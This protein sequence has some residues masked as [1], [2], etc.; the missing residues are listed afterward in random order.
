[1]FDTAIAPV[2]LAPVASGTLALASTIESAKGYAAASKAT[3]TRR[4]YRGAW[5][6][7]AAWCEAHGLTSLPAAPETVALYLAERADQ[8][9]KPASLDLYLAAVS[10]AHRA[11]GHPSPREAAAVRAVRAGIRRTHGTAQRQVAPATA[12]TLR[13]M[14]AELPDG[15]I[16][17]RDAALLLCGFAAALRRSELVALDL[18]DI[19]FT[20]EGAIVTLRR[21]KTDQ[22]AAGRVIAVP[23][24]SSA[25]VCPVR[26]LRA[27]LDVAGIMSGAIFRA[28]DRHGRI[29]PERLTDR[30]VALIVKR[31]AERVGLDAKAFAGHSLRAGLATSAALAGKSERSIMQ[32]TGHRSATMVRRYIRTAEIWRDNAAAGLL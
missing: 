30:A 2:A 18:S 26:R 1:M 23:F 8:G 16:G 29:A 21:S 14:L 24:A 28:V 15:T 25:D 10:E 7:F 12:D 17:A 4:A 19:N 13:R 32:T 20:A 22:E 31:S 5:Q 3:N 11:A 6:A 27:W 9:A